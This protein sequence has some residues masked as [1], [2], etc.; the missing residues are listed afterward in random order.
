MNVA[1]DAL[2]LYAVT[3]RTWLTDQTLAQAVE[4][5][6]QGGVTFLQLRE[7]NLDFPS[8]LREACCLKTLAAAYHVPFVINDSLEI[9]LACGAD[10]V[11]LGQSDQSVRQARAL[12]GDRKIIGASVQTVAQAKQAQAEGADYLGAGAVFPTASKQDATALTLGRL[13]A[14]CQAVR[15]PVVAI[16]GIRQQNILQLA[17]SGIAGAAMISAIYAEPDIRA[18]AAQMKMLC[19]QLTA[20]GK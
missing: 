17:G 20:K 5:S 8:F 19:Q 9:A 11:H 14:I 10:G 6:L 7:K 1:K 13:Q 15:L 3:D 18:A 4:A 2:L 16:G 12:L